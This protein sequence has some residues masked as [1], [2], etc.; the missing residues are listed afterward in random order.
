MV[1]V[2]HGVGSYGFA[3]GAAA[4]ILA[5]VAVVLL[6]PSVSAL[7]DFKVALAGGGA[8][9]SAI[10]DNAISRVGGTR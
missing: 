5:L 7:P 3:A 9:V 1:R 10:A 4:L 2:R 6:A 8:K